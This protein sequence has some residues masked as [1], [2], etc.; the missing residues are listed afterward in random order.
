[1]L[2]ED[3]F[4]CDSKE[5]FEPEPVRGQLQIPLDEEDTCRVYGVPEDP[6]LRERYGVKVIKEW[7]E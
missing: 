2:L 4:F 6:D 5:Y 1:M 7:T 3:C